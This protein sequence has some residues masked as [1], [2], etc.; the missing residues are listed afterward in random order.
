MVVGD[1]RKRSRGEPAWTTSPIIKDSSQ[2]IPA[3]PGRAPRDAVGPGTSGAREPEFARTMW[4]SFRRSC[5]IWSRPCRRP[6][7]IYA[8]GLSMGGVFSYR[9]ACEMSG[10]VRGHR[11]GRGD[12]GGTI[13]PSRQPGRSSSYPRHG[14]R[15]DSP[16]AAAGATMT[17]ADRSWPAPQQGV[18]SWSRFDGCSA[19]QP[20]RSDDGPATCTTYGQCRATVEFC[21]ISGEG[22]GWPD[23]ASEHIWAFFAA[24]PKQ[25]LEERVNARPPSRTHL[26]N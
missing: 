13:V 1:V 11:A 18:S 19:E 25:A 23:G 9:L 14:R 17:A 10:H 21:V 20:A 7:R 22:H 8:T 24:H 16:Q 5:A 4:P 3:G 6:S 12:H 15:P 26:V 2:S